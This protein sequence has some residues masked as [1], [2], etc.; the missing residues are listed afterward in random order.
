M[1][2]NTYSVQLAKTSRAKCKVCKEPIQKGELKIFVE[3]PLREGA[4]FAMTTSHH[5]SCFKIPRKLT[6]DGVDVEEFVEDYLT[7]ND[8]GELLLDRK[9]EILEMLREAASKTKTKTKK[10]KPSENDG[11]T[12]DLMERLKEAAKMDDSDEEEPAKKKAKTKAQSKEEKEFK[13]MLSVYRKYQKGFTVATLKDFLRW[14]QQLLTGTKAFVLFKVIDGELHGRLSICPLC[15][16]DLK[17][18]E[19]D[20]DKIHCSGRYD[21]DIGRR[22]PCSYTAPRLGNP[23][24]VR[25]HPFH[26]EEPPE[27][28]KEAMKQFREDAREGGGGGTKPADNPVAQELLKKSESLE[29]KLDFTTNTGR[30]HAVGEFVALVKGKVDLPENRNAK[31]E[32]GKLVMANCNGK[33]PKEIMQVIFDKYGFANVKQEKAA[34]AEAAAEASCANPKNAALILAL[35]ECSKYYFAESNA[36]AALSYK[37]AIATLTGLE[38]EITE[39]N[40]LSFSKGKTKL[41]GIGKGTAEKMKEFCRTGTFKKLEEKREAHK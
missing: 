3:A 29:G 16:G 6:A 21:E 2:G 38:E 10:A 28:E 26:L 9:E 30:K 27:E 39:K 17:F 22:I 23:E 40:A 14:N 31:M 34:A 8:D 4:N 15:Q 12:T 25:A 1:S 20:Y 24:T 32:I 5:V 36:N 35:E 41:P 37:K 19:D 7:A 18:V 33:S 11:E 13:A